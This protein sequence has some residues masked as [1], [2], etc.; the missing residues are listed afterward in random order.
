MLAYNKVYTSNSIEDHN[1][2]Y[3]KTYTWK[4]LAE[5]MEDS[6]VLMSIWL[7]LT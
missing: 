1:Y 2:I 5:G 4:K 7:T 3:N 6:S